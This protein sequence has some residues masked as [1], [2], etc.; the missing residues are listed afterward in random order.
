M[1]TPWN[2]IAGWL[3]VVLG[4]MTG[5]AIGLGFHRTDFGGGYDSWRRR[6]A[7]L[8]HISFFGLGLLNIAFALSLDVLVDEPPAASHR[9]WI[10]I[11]S[12]GWIVSLVTMPTVCFLSA[13]RPV[14][15]HAFFVPVLAALTGAVV[16]LAQ[17]VASWIS[18]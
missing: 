15:R 10:D 4:M 7:R 11:A 8:G 9:L 5:A 6:L 17:E 16:F 1:L 14:F 13:W 12:I 3:A 2:L 18:V